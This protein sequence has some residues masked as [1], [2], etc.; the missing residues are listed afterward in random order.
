[1]DED[2]KKKIIDKLLASPVGRTKLAD[3]MIDPIRQ[4]RYAPPICGTCGMPLPG[5]MSQMLH[6]DEE[7]LIYYVMES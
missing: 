5:V 7:C 4:R 1:M 6:T 3:A 2:L